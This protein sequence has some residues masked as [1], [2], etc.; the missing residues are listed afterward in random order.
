MVGKNNRFLKESK[1]NQ[2]Y[3][4]FSLRK[5]SIGVVSVAIAAGFYMGSSQ[6]VMADTTTSVPTTNVTATSN[7]NT[8]SANA[9]TTSS[10]SNVQSKTDNSLAPNETYVTVKVNPNATQGEESFSDAFKLNGDAYQATQDGNYYVKTSKNDPNWDGTV[11]LTPNKTHQSGNFTLNSQISLEHDFDLE[12]QVYLGEYQHYNGSLGA[13]GIGFA[14][15]K[16]NTDKA[17]ADGRRIGIGDLKD[18]VGFKLDTYYN[19]SDHGRSDTLDRPYGAF[20]TTSD[21]TPYYDGSSK[22]WTSYD[23]DEETD[24]AQAIYYDRS[25]PGVMDNDWHDF[26]IH[27]DAASQQLTVK[28]VV[29]IYNWYGNPTKPKTLVWHRTLTDTDPLS[30]AVTASTGDCYNLQMFKF[31]S[32]TY[33]KTASVNVK[34]I[35]DK[36]EDISAFVKDRNATYTND[37]QKTYYKTSHPDVINVPDT[38]TYYSFVGL[39]NGSL[40]P[41]GNLTKT[42]DNGTVTYVYKE[43]NNGQKAQLKFYDDDEE[44][45]I[46]DDQGHD[47]VQEKADAPTKEIKFSDDKEKQLEKQYK[48]AG[49]TKENGDKL[50]GDSFAAVKFGNY[51]TDDDTTQTFV[52]HLNH[53]TK[54]VTQDSTI[55]QIIH[56]VYAD[57]TKAG[58]DN[59]QTV[60]FTQTGTTDLV[61]G[62]TTWTPTTAQTF[63]DVT[64]P[65]ITGYTSDQTSVKGASVNVGDQNVVKTVTY[66][67]NEQNATITYVDDMTGETLKTDTAAGKYNTAISFNVDPTTQINTYKG[68]GYKLVSNDFES[69]AKFAL[70]NSKNNFTVHLTHATKA[71]SREDDVKQTV[72]YVMADGSKAPKD[73]IQTL[74]FTEN[75]V[76]DLVTGETTW[77]SSEAQSFTDVTSPVLDGYTADQTNIQGTAVNFGD[78]DLT[79]T[80]TYTANEQNA[81]ITYVDD[82]TGETLK[83]DTAAGKYNTAISF[84]VD[85]TTQINTYEGQGYKLVSNDFE[86]GAKFASDNSKNNFTVHLTH[87]TKAASR[88]DD[89]KQTV[90]YVMADGSKAPKDNI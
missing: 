30:F 76:T 69:G 90:H 75:G 7:G 73:N 3:Q 21:A 88:E 61:T 78:D 12:G 9:N 82:M 89:V 62:K 49:V 86:S 71:A 42:G 36:G 51:D 52:V 77:T 31:K 64:S 70:D 17:G 65:T 43:I 85:P 15:H 4:R 48:F 53:G 2:R 27:Y 74:H 46:Q 38:N 6:S 40:D 54:Q 1:N 8:T 87:A 63:K 19:G 11:I 5:F 44:Q 23:V 72:H 13:D 25:N 58:D 32:F 67:A 60:K 56:Y 14:F 34:Y 37:G 26:S 33:V 41:E 28:L 39:G 81:T 24:S 45:F 68:Q 83:T 47:L 35:T 57:G 22:K 79:K 50:A 80:V 18:A 29:P 84:N 20:V 59:V 10:S 66:T 16:D 55:K